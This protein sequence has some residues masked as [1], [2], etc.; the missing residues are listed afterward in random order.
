VNSEAFTSGHRH[1][2][3]AVAIQHRLPT[4]WGNSNEARDGGLMSYGVDIVEPFR[5]AATYIDRIL[6]GTKPADLPVQ[7][8]TRFD[9]VINL[10]TARAIGLNVSA[11]MLS[12]A[13]EVI[14]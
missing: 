5:Q 1:Q 6:R 11:D 13:N 12:I 9:L 3:I 14:E 4:I 2:I 10:K 8:P 7:A